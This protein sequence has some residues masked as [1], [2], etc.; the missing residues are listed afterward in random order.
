MTHRMSRVSKF[1]TFVEFLDNFKK[2]MNS[3][4]NIFFD[5]KLAQF[6]TLNNLVVRNLAFNIQKSRYML[7]QLPKRLAHQ[8]TSRVMKGESN[9]IKLTN[10]ADFLGTLYTKRLLFIQ[11]RRHI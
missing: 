9:T 5:I 10:L 4:I 6:E 1:F 8:M 2:I 7:L 11:L 3:F